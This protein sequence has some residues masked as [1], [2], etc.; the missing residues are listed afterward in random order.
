MRPI[1]YVTTE[2]APSKVE[3]SLRQKGLIA[4][5][6]HLLGFVDAFNET[7][8]LPSVERHD[9]VGASSG[10]LTGL[11]ISISK[12]QERIGENSLLIFD[13]LTTPYLM[14]GSEI[15]RFMRTTLL[16]FA[17]EGNAV[18]ACMD[19]G[20]GREEDLVEDRT[21]GWLEDH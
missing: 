13:S 8:G 14:S 2:S 16:R 18:L 4:S 15:L 10:D 9:I 3:D 1:I 7:V 12:L 11:S 17:A 21:D 20:C 5:L 6:P 19:E